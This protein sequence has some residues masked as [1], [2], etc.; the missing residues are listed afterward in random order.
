MKKNLAII[1]CA[2]L[3]LLLLSCDL[4]KKKDEKDTNAP[5]NEPQV[6]QPAQPTQ[7]HTAG[8]PSQARL[9]FF[10]EAKKIE[11]NFTGDPNIFSTGSSHNSAD[12]VLFFDF[13]RIY[14]RKLC[15]AEYGGDAFAVYNLLL[16]NGYVKSAEV[17]RSA[18]RKP[19]TGEINWQMDC[20]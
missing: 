11:S 8:T 20:D 16:D 18:F 19:Y 9:D 17:W 14:G 1:T 12:M 10:K 4:F 5:A 2:V 7:T 15:C 3:V 13:N 6:Q